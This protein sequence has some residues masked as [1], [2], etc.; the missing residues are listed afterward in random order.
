MKILFLQDDFP[1]ISFGGAG[2]STYE[3]ALGMQKAGHKVFIITTVRTESEVGESVY[4]GLTVFKIVSDYPGRWRAWM[5]LYN[6]SVVRRV[7]ELLKKIRPDVVH[8]NN[9]HLHLSYH[10]LKISKRYAKAVVLTFRD[11]MAVTYGKLGTQRYVETLD[12]HVTWRDNLMQ[13]GKRFNPFRN[14]CIKRYLRYTDRLFSVSDSLREALLQNGIKGVETMHTGVDV[15]TYQTAPDAVARFKV[16][17]G[18][19][20]KKVLL[21]VGRL[22]G[23]KGGHQAIRVLARVVQEEPT[24]VLLVAGSVDSYAREM[25]EEAQRLGVGGQLIFTDWIEREEMK[26]AYAAADVVLVLSLY[27]DPFPRTAL[28]AMAAGKPVVGTRYGGAPEAI[29]NSV[30]GYVVNPFKVEEVSEKA[31]DLLQ[32]KDKMTRLGD[33][34][35]ERMRTTL[36]LEQNV[37]EYSACY[38]QLLSR[39]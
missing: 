36:S 2:I 30:T 38:E 13:A 33:A 10:S 17:Y 39:G 34:G 5:S 26:A 22:S 27:L 4:R 11:T 6:P 24:A 37:K 19:E 7:E 8:A 21:F 12:T 28:E 20:H 9:I 25:Q 29:Q 31:L 35:R 16:A 32:D 3:L 14:V 1:P 23:A 15:A 18:L